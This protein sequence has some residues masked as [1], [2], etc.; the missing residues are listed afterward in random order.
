MEQLY[1]LIR[2]KIKE[3]EE[4]SQRVAAE[5]VAGMIRGSKYWTVE[6][7]DE[8]WSKLTPFLNEAFMNISSEA[9]NNWCLC[10][11]FAV[12]DVDPR[13]MYHA[14]EFMRS[15]I[16]TPSTANAL[17]ETS[18][19]HLIEQ[20]SNFEWRIPAEYF[21]LMSNRNYFIKVEGKKVTSAEYIVKRHGGVLGLCAMVLSSPYD[22]SIHVPDALMLLCEHSHDPNLIQ[23]SIKNALSEFRRTHHDSWHEHRKNFTEDQLV[24]LADVLISPNYYI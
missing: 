17:I 3:K 16:N 21:R 11:R 6:M 15:L 22:I 18:R 1:S 7:L 9:V 10:F 23:R 14:V 8:L 2:K 5:I 19:W 20:L 12:A 13:R 24:I 4:G